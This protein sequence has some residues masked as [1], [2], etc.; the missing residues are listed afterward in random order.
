M[1]KWYLRKAKNK[2]ELYCIYDDFDD[3]IPILLLM[4]IL[5]NEYDNIIIQNEESDIMNGIYTRNLIINNID[6]TIYEEL[7]SLTF[8]SNSKEGDA[9]IYHISAILKA[10][11][12]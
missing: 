7:S 5:E 6:F 8:S 2:Y 4:N 10:D 9:I 11:M 1:N 3:E 12:Q